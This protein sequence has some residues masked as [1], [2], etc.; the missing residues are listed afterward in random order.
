MVN[1]RRCNP[2]PGLQPIVS[3]FHAVS[4]TS[5]AD[6]KTNER[7]AECVHRRRSPALSTFRLGQPAVDAA[8]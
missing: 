8:T 5:T 3:T 7:T 1:D 6:S 4:T 2:T